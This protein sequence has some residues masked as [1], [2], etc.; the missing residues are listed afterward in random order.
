MG[1]FDNKRGYSFDIIEDGTRTFD[2][3]RGYEIRTFDNNKR[4]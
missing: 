4:R 2:N 3:K 1:T